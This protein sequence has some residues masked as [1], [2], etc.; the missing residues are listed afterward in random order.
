MTNENIL[1]KPLPHQELILKS[2]ATEIFAGGAAGPGKT[3][4]LIMDVLYQIH[5][6][7]AN[8]VIFRRN[9]SELAEIL[10]RTSE[11]YPHFGAVGKYQSASYLWRFPSGARV[12][13]SHMNHS[14]DRYKHRGSEYTSIAYDESTLFEEEMITFLFSRLRTTD[15]ELKTKLRFFLASNPGSISHDWHLKRY[16][17]WLLQDYNTDVLPSY[18]PKHGPIGLPP[19]KI[20]WVTTIDG[21]EFFSEKP[22][23]LAISRTA[24]PC[25]LDQNPYLGDEYQ[26]ALKQL[27][28]VEYNRVRYGDWLYRPTTKLHFDRN[29]V[30]LISR[31]EFN[32]IYKGKEKEFKFSRG[33]DFSTGTGKDFSATALIATHKQTSNAYLLD[34][35]DER[36]EISNIEFFIRANHEKDIAN[37][38]HDVNVILEQE[39]G[40]ASVYMLD[41]LIRKLKGFKIYKE[42]HSKDKVTRFGG[43][44]SATRNGL[45]FAIKDAWN[46]RAFNQMEDLGSE[47]AINDDICDAVSTSYNWLNPTNTTKIKQGQS[48]LNFF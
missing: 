37:G 2:T 29:N 40:S 21:E 38:Y 36:V 12:L 8:C 35:I 16:A 7:N 48:P 47:N 39:P 25:S 27:S 32:T 30:K 26:A 46:F 28:P 11:I 4:C 20:M 23:H 22:S 41:S 6:K 9:Y 13:L 1:F 31:L 17:P 14:E 34:A 5:N 19:G 24:I 43:F 42:R 44:G 10:N 3:T 15:P 33:Y 45:V 18:T